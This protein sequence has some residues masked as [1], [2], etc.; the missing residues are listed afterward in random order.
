MSAPGGPAVPVQRVLLLS[1][2][3]LHAVDLTA[4]VKAVPDSALAALSRTGVTYTAAATARPSDSFPGLLAILTGGSPAATGVWYDVSYDRALS[5]PG[6]NCAATGA[7]VPYDSTINKNPDAL[8][9]GGGIDPARLP[10][11]PRRGC[12]PVFP[13]D[14]LRVNT[15]FEVVRSA[16][17]R[18]AWA[19]KHLSYEILRGPSGQGVDDLYTPEID[20][21]HGSA[22]KT[23]QGAEANDDLKVRAIVNEIQG[24][25]HAGAAAA[26]VPAL[27]GM[28]F[29]AVSVA[30]KLPGGGYRDAGGTP[31]AMLLEA[32]RHTDGSIGQFVAELRARNLLASTL[33]VITAKHGQSPID[34]TRR[35]IVDKGMIPKIVNTVQSNLLAQ[36]TQ[37]SVSLLWLRD[38]NKTAAVVAALRAAQRFAG[39]DAIFAGEELAKMFNGLVADSRTPDIIVQPALRV[40][41]TG[42]TATKIAEHGGFTDDDTGAALLV[43]M[44]GL[45]A[46]ESRVPVRTAQIAPTLLDALKLDPRALRA[47]Q[48][49]K[50]PVL[51]GLGTIAASSR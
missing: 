12:A 5:A 30:Q 20:A 13:H 7:E 37:D 26:P 32:L 46:G 41:Y 47:V 29:Q 25:D 45:E 11:D 49:E 36:A 9:G 17:R 40:I 27:F 31:S 23:V 16:D 24:K 18:T 44:P 51:P 38:H 19:D 48:R 50:T 2:D 35:Q 33:I 39:I 21:D 6:T 8:D 14:Y 1:V 10:R 34:P 42:L 4:F 15:I 43:S 22:T 3:G 28:N